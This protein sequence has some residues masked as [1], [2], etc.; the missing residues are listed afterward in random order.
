MCSCSAQRNTGS[1]VG[2]S[3]QAAYQ[4]LDLKLRNISDSSEIDIVQCDRAWRHSIGRHSEGGHA[5]RIALILPA[6]IRSSWHHS[7]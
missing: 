7:A 6:I 5:F 1:A 3:L 2:S 4:T